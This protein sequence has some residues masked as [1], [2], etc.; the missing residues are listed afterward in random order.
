MSEKLSRRDFMRTTALAA[1]GVALAACTPKATEKPAEAEKPAEEVAQPAATP[2]I[3]LSVWGAVQEDVLYTANYNPEIEKQYNV[4]VEFLSVPDFN[5]YYDKLVQLH[6]AGT[7][8]DLPRHNVQRLGYVIQ[9]DMLE[10]LAPRYQVANIDTSDFH[11]GIMP[12]MSREGGNKIYATPQDEN[13]FGLYYNPKLFEEAGLPIPDDDYTM[14]KLVE[15]AQ[16]LTKRDS[17]GKVTQ[18]GYIDW[19]DWWN[20]QGFVLADGGK[21]WDNLR[22]PGEQAV[23][24]DAWYKALDRWKMLVVDLD[25][26]AGNQEIGN[27]GANVFFEQSRAAMFPDGTWRAP[28]VKKAAPDLKFAVATFPKGTRKV[29]RGSSCCWGT[30]TGTPDKELI[31]K[32][33]SGYLLTKEAQLDYWQ[34]LWVAPP[35][36]LSVIKSEDFKKV[37]GL[38][39]GGIEYPGYDPNDATEFDRMDK[40]IVTTLSNGWD[41][42]ECLG[43]NQTILER[44]MVA[45]IQSVLV[46]DSTVSVKEAIDGAVKRTNDEI[47]ANA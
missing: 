4:K 46:K 6:A 32:I 24:D 34:I 30:S 23:V 28:F 8:V 39:A 25:V 43:D 18:Y 44:E 38:S 33:S 13:L 21:I 45:A 15:D 27:L 36:S 3:V 16:K 22:S 20:F 7:P 40:W 9:K 5:N 2:K 17:T 19:W 29:S 10:D 12:P 47:K 35:P 14:D 1:T 26:A 42:Q 41:T 37:K 31:W 11:K